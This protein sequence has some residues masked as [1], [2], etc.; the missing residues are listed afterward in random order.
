MSRPFFIYSQTA[1]QNILQYPDTSS[2][3]FSLHPWMN[4]TCLC[5][6]V[7]LDLIRRNHGNSFFLLY[8]VG[9]TIVLM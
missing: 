8:S 5:F 6:Y 1:Y 2:Q 4:T 3:I 9:C 7:L